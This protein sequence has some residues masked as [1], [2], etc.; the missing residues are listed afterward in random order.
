MFRKSK[1]LISIFLTMCFIFSM[2]I[3]S[4]A[5]TTQSQPEILE[6]D[7]KTISVQVLV[8]NDTMRKVVAI[9]DNKISSTTTYNKKTTDIKIEE[10]NLESGSTK[11]IADT[12]VNRVLKNKTNKQNA[13][14]PEVS[15]MATVVARA[16]G[17]FWSTGYTYW[18]DQKWL[19]Y[20]SSGNGKYATETSSN[21]SN[22]TSFKSSVDSQKNYEAAAIAATGTAIC[23]SAVAIVTAPTGAVSFVSAVTAL[24]GAATAGYSLY[25]AWQQKNNCDF[26]FSRVS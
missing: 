5:A 25:S 16:T 3:Q 15:I 14:E 20:N 9:E 13:I 19:I 1:K 8:D 11:V 2:C 22:L 18:S 26:Y 23:S 17:K 10:T 12:N 21:S 4:Y 24:G 6:V 7:G